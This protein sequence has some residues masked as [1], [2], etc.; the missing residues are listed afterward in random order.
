MQIIQFTKKDFEINIDKFCSLYKKVFTAKIDNEILYQRYIDNGQEDILMF[1]AVE[2]DHIIANYS[3]VP[4]TLMA[5]GTEIKAALSLNTM[6]D[7]QYQGKGIAIILARKLYAYM[8]EKKYDLV[9]GFPNCDA[10]R[11]FNESLGWRTIYEIPTLK[12]SVADIKTPYSINCEIVQDN[13]DS[14]CGNG[15]DDKIYAKHSRNYINWRYRDNKEKEYHLLSAD[16]ANWIIYQRYNDEINITEVDC[17]DN[18][19]AHELI[20]TVVNIAINEHYISVTTWYSINTKIHSFLETMG[21]KVTS[22]VR[23]FSARCFNKAMENEVYDYNNWKICMGDD[24]A[25]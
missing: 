10:N 21:F 13:Y 1:V 18:R 25:Y 5:N 2:D 14:I 24:N 15:I 20:K 6:V 19:K 9:Y 8:A 4:V 3:A 22:P 16:E 23:V 7:P 11:M 12:L 17:S